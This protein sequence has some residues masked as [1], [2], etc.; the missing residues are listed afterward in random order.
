MAEHRRGDERGVADADAVVRLVALLQPAQDR[1]RV[2]DRR[3]A[4]VDGCEAALER[5]VLLDVLAVLVE[6]RR[7]DAAQLAAREHRLQQVRRVDGALGRACADDRVQLVDEED[8]A[9]VRALDLGEHR[10]QPLLE[11]AA[12]LR[13]GEQRADVERP[14]AAVLQ[15]FGHVAGDDALGEPLDDRGLADAGL[16]DQHRVVL[17]AAREDLDHAADLLV[18]SDHRVEL[19]RLGGLGEVAAELLRAPGRSPRGPAR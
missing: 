16:A 3:L 11:L 9:A 6:R 14:D 1:D 13:A 17:R 8:D 4:D 7:A 19:A 18:A 12:V 5:R 15:P 10:L 2:D